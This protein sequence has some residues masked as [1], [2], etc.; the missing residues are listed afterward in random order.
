MR[1]AILT[2]GR[3]DWTGLSVVA[4]AVASDTEHEVILLAG[5]MHGRSG[6]LPESLDGIAVAEKI[7]VLPRGDSGHAVADAA[8]R[9]TAAVASSLHRAN[10]DALLLLGDRTETLAA[11]V[12]ATCLRLPVLHVH[13]GEETEGAVDNACR[14]AI[15]KLSHVHFVAHESFARRVEQMG[16]PRERIVVTGAPALD[17]AV[18]RAT[19]SKDALARDLGLNAA[20]PWILCT[21]HPTT[22]GRLPPAEELRAV[23]HALEPR[24]AS[25]DQIVITR[26]NV[27][28]GHEGLAREL[29]AFVRRHGGDVVVHDALGAER[30]FSLLAHAVAMIGNSSSGIIEAPLFRLPT[31]NV[32]DRQRGRLRGANVIDV[33]ADEAAI[34]DA[35]A[36]ALS[37]AMRDALAGTTSPYGDGRA[38]ARIAGAIDRLAP[39]LCTAVKVFVDRPEA[40]S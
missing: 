29:D 17:A 21:H 36:R 4:R 6:S 14:H 15:T 27:D 18:H 33:P 39:E 23:L 19:I 10:A 7:E 40:P 20:K 11:A 35:L 31:V 37:P 9:T 3:Q 1:I 12:A 2:T 16:E 5:G 32:G 24:V 8:G 25:G 22:L 26:P 30:Y 28:E 13:G 34:A 38:G